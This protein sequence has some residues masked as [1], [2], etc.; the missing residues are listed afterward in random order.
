MRIYGVGKVSAGT[1]SYFQ[2]RI[3]FIAL[4][5]FA[6]AEVKLDG[7]L[8]NSSLSRNAPNKYADTVP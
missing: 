6:T 1:I 7:D 8:A 3:D 5:P 4:S 2:F